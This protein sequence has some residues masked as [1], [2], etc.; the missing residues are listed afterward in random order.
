[1]NVSVAKQLS[2]LGGV[3]DQHGVVPDHESHICVSVEVDH[4][5]REV[6]AAV[7]REDAETLGLVDNV[8]RGLL[9]QFGMSVAEEEGQSATDWTVTVQ[10]AHNV[11][12]LASD[13]DGHDLRL[14]NEDGGT[15]LWCSTCFIPTMGFA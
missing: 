15:V 12:R 1:M 7:D 6:W 8:T 9:E 13:H 2:D 11:S 14:I 5:E 3:T 4:A 10:R